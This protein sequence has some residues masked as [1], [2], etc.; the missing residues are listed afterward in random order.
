[1]HQDDQANPDHEQH[2][3]A[4]VAL[5]G[6]NPYVDVP[7]SVVAA[8]G[9]GPKA[10]VLVKLARGGQQLGEASPAQPGKLARDADRLKAIGRLAPG[11]WFRTTLVPQ[12]NAPTRLYLDTWM[13]AALERNVRKTIANLL[14]QQDDAT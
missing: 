5:A 4:Q 12:R 7:A 11:G 13:R 10:A 6:V 14:G 2:F 8:L 9:G 3:T 1:M